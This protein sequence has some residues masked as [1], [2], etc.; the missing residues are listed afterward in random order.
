MRADLEGIVRKAIRQAFRAHTEHS[1]LIV[2]HRRLEGATVSAVL[3]ALRIVEQEPAAEVAIPERMTERWL[4]GLDADR[5]AAVVRQLSFESGHYQNY[6]HARRQSAR[7]Q[8]AYDEQLRRT[9]D[10]SFGE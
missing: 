6:D 9:R 2:G 1:G 10:E 8:R 3:S 7:W 4:R 5:L